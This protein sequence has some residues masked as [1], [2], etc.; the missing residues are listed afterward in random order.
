MAVCHCLPSGKQCMAATHGTASNE[1]VAL[2]GDGHQAYP[3]MRPV[4]LF[5]TVYLV[6]VAETSLVD[7]MRVGNVTPDLLALVAVVWLLTVAG[8]RAFL[9]AGAIALVGDLIAPGRLGV[10]TAW[11]LLVGYGITCLRARLQGATDGRGFTGAQLLWQV[12]MV[13]AAVTV[14]AAAVGLSGRLLGDIWLPLSTILT[15]AAGV[16]IYTAGAALPVLMVVGW[17][18]EPKPARRR[19][20]EPC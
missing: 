8:P 19:T 10:G 4:L 5:L 17:V 11:M 9:I 6:A 1:A 16:G 14:W 20:L 15:R 18:R 12:P 3:T 2:C 7:V 13:A